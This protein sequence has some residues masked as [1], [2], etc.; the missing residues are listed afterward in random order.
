L[1]TRLS[2]ES[3]GWSAAVAPRAGVAFSPGSQG[4][5]VLRAGIGLFYSLLPLLAADFGDNPT[6]VVSQFDTTGLP[7]GLPV[8]Y[9]YAYVGG[10]D[11][12]TGAALPQG[13]G[14]SPRNLTWNLGGERQLGKK[15]L[16]RLGYLDSH[17]TYVFVAHPFTAAPGQTSFLG[18]S[19]NGSSRYREWE[20]TVHFTV[21]ENN[22]VNASY[23][24]SRTRGDLNNLSAVSIPF[25][26]P[27]IR[28]NVYGILPSD[29]PNRM[30]GWGI[31]SL[32]KKFKFSPLADW[33]SGYPYSNVDV[34]QNYVGTPNGARFANFFSLDVKFYRVFRLPFLSAGSKVHHIRLGFYSLNVTNHG[35]F[36]AVYNNVTAPNFGQFAGFMDRRDGA[37][38]DFVD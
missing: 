26:Q 16:L 14:T 19:N 24:W 1:G 27:V 3:Q 30:V 6:R 5:T 28:P 10:V 20:S 34:L 9:T 11:P 21:H 2:S 36:N 15:V 4:K 18:L 35:N 8:S 7:I 33:H 12:L 17:S 38:I 23:I 31:F 22:E 32:P 29:I 13:P 37:M 25:A